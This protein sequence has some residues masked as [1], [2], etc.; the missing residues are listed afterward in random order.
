MQMISILIH[1]LQLF[2]LNPL[3]DNDKTFVFT[4]IDDLSDDCLYL[5]W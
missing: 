5:V 4:P 3:E 2:T 1:A